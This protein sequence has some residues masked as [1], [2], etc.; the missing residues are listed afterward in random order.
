MINNPSERPYFT[1]EESRLSSGEPNNPGDQDTFEQLMTMEDKEIRFWK[2][3][4]EFKIPFL[5]ECGMD[6]DAILKDYDDRM[7]REKQLGINFVREEVEKAIGKM[8]AEEFDKFEEEGEIPASL[9]R[10]VDFDPV[11]SN[12]VDKTYPDIIIMTIYDLLE[13]RY[14]RENENGEEAEA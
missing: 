10:L 5:D 3:H 11:T 12:F 8:T 13:A 1:E 2:S 6:W 4:P 7:A 14:A 9:K